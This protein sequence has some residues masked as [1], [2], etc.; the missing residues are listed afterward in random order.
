M[1]LVIFA[2]SHMSNNKIILPISILLG[3]IILGGFYYAGELNKQDSIERQQKI[4]LQAKTDADSLKMKK[5]KA[6]ED[7][8]NNLKC[9]NLLSELQRRWNNV[10]GIYYNDI[11][12]TCM[13]KYLD[14]GKHEEGALEDMQNN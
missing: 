12:N 5:D 4:E 14:K 3:C 11:R 8:N 7:F 10:E 1:N 2:G 6:D 13:V 9:Q